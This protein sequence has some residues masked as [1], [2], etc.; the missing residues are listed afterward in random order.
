ME[1][2]NRRYLEFVSAIEDPTVGIKNLEKISQP[3]SDGQR[4]YRGFNLFLSQD[5]KRSN[6]INRM[7]FIENS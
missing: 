7:Q 6:S 4:S 5:L 2:A 3:T 1:A